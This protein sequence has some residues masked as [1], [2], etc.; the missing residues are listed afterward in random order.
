VSENQAKR[1]VKRVRSQRGQAGVRRER[2]RV[3]VCILVHPS[4][5]MAVYD[6]I[7]VRLHF[8][9]IIDYRIK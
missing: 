6:L 3:N 4:A 8:H 7:K 5:C 9:D 1:E 2:N